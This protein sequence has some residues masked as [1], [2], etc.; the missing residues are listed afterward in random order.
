MKTVT[1]DVIVIGAGIAGAA[2]AWE[3]SGHMNTLLLEQEEQPGYHATG[4]SAALFSELYGDPLNRALIR[5]ANRFFQQTPEGFADSPIL[6]KAG[7]LFCYS[8]DEMSLAEQ[9]FAEACKVSKVELWSERQI[10][11]RVPLLKKG[12]LGKAIWEPGAAAIDVHSLLH[13]FLKGFRQKG[14]SLF[15]DSRVQQITACEAGFVIKTGKGQF[16]A[17]RI[18]NAAGAWA[19]Q[20]AV[21]AGAN[22]LKMVPKRRTVIVVDPP[23]N[24]DVSDW[25]FLEVVGKELYFKPDA[26]Q[27]FVS[28]EDAS[29]DIPCD[30]QPEELDV[31]VAADHI[32]KYLNLDVRKINNKWA[33]LRTFAADEVPVVGEDPDIPGFFW[34]AGLGGYGIQTAQPLAGIM[35]SL[36]MERPLPVY[37][38]Q[39]YPDLLSSI[40]PRR[41]HNP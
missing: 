3:L 21:M 23:E 22:S 33:G 25:P 16:Q 38:E 6:Q 1:A 37:L 39:A 20:V 19:D 18:I 7:A 24:I 35:A 27:L 4:R 9:L 40:S 30:A 41:F 11:S 26:G 32:M 2:A 28:P 36:V 31:A 10:M 29:P 13:G 8:P 14:G 17:P 34:L 15:T 12:L 5:S